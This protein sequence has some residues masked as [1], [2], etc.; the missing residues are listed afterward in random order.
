VDE[1]TTYAIQVTNGSGKPLRGLTLHLTPTEQFEIV[2]VQARTTSGES[3][4]ET[5]RGVDGW[6][7]TT[8]EPL[9]PVG[10][11][12]FDVQVNAREIGAGQLI[13]VLKA[14]GLA[15]PVMAREMTV[16]DPP[17]VSQE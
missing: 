4:V 5:E 11:L 3:A 17:A 2:A 12:I 7:V 14:E 16:V 10:T 15:T 6:S 1:S 9:A 8:R 13:A